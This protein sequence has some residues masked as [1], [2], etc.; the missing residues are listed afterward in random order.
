MSLKNIKESELKDLLDE[1][2]TDLAKAFE[3]E[4]DKLVKAEESSSSSSSMEKGS[5]SMEKT[6][7]PASEGSAGPDHKHDDR[8]VQDVNKLSGGVKPNPMTEKGAKLGKDDAPPEKSKSP[9]AS[10]AGSPAPEASQSSAAPGGDAP[11]APDAGV[12]GPEAGAAPGAD[13]GAPADPA[14]DAG[15]ALTPEA[16]QAEY[17]KL[18]PEELDMHIQAALAAKAALAGPAAG[19][20]PMG[21]DGGAPMAPPPAS[22][23]PGG[24][25]M[26][27]NE[28]YHNSPERDAP[29]G[30]GAPGMELARKH[31]AEIAELK[32]LV[33]S[34]AED[35]DKVFSALKSY[36][37][38]PQ[39]KAITTVAYVAKSEQPTSK[40]ITPTTIRAR[41]L[42]L[43]KQ[44]DL[45]KSDRQ[46]INDFYDHKVSIDKLA[47]L[48]EGFTAQA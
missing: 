37:E 32:A 20:A 10:A 33:K 27:M 4:K 7:V 11:P 15:M 30:K 38:Q 2:A 17:S 6:A 29:H 26:A 42:E 43:S 44:P 41:L 8:Q 19:A 9:E 31:E 34:Q 21:A 5:S 1:V 46:L 39:R 45:K 28:D 16:L 18:P 23:S 24:A 12:G 25:P 14:A 36:V 13:A 35:Y 47:H 40:V 48:F 22:P 3:S